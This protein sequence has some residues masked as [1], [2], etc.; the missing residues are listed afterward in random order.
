[1]KSA[2]RKD[3]E[4]VGSS[5]LVKEL[6][7]PYFDPNWHFHP[8][9]QLF[10]VEEGTGTRFIG[11]SIR[12]F[13][14][15]DLVFLGPNLPHLWRSD[16]RYHESDSG[17][18]TKGIVVYFAEDFLG[19]AFFGRPEMVLLQQLLA[20]SR[21]GMEWIGATR[22]FA[23]EA[24]RSLAA[25]PPTFERLLQLLSLL[26]ALSHSTE[27]AP[28][29]SPDYTNT[30]KPSETNRMQIIHTYVLENYAGTIQ[31]NDVAGRVG[32]SPSAF[33]RYFKA[34]ANKTFSEFITEIR[35]GQACKLL[36]EDNLNVT[37]ISYECGFRTLSN[38]NRQFKEVTAQ[39]PSQ[40]KRAYRELA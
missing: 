18:V 8:H 39:T 26:D 6:R 4:A 11:D 16:A 19:D 40:Y 34:H 5:Y 24:L 20:H 29:T 30:M 31:L 9:Y 27:Y 32:M 23:E 38:F 10:L 13:S 28:I 17:L 33:C 22:D 15:G 36:M 2:L 25:Q 12:S 1:M 35:V 7:E 21:R 3:L 37:Q 14:P